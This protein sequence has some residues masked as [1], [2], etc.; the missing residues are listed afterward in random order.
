MQTITRVN[1][2]RISTRKI[3]LVTDSISGLTIDEASDALSVIPKRGA[4][5]IDKIL[6]NAVAN[7]VNNSRLEKNNLIIKKIDINQGQSLK[8]YRPSTRGRTH[9]YL[10]RATNIR[11][12]LEE[13]VPVH[14][15]SDEKPATAET[16]SLKQDK[17]QKSKI[18]GKE[19]KN[20]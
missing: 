12:V 1:N 11:I 3:R 9:P 8:R 10:K 17:S 2:I 16:Q 5:T 19:N 6:K 4:K 15:L 14:S 18:F 7:A 13:K 20:E